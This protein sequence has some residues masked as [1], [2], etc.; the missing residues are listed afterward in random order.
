MA[1]LTTSMQIVFI[2]VS[3]LCT[4]PGLAAPSSRESYGPSGKSRTKLDRQIII[5]ASMHAITDH[6][7][8]EVVYRMS[9][10]CVALVIA[11]SLLYV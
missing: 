10:V 6:E 7:E 9:T 4:A 1:I 11:T 8:L 2:T 3:A 5:L